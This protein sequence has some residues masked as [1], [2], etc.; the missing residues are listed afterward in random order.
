MSKV[1]QYLARKRHRS[2]EVLVHVYFQRL[3]CFAGLVQRINRAEIPDFAKST[4]NNCFGFEKF[5]DTLIAMQQFASNTCTSK[6]DNNIVGNNERT[7]STKE[8]SMALVNDYTM[9]FADLKR[10][11]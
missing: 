9:Y 2:S 1:L 3:L 6:A 7:S 10:H 4:E 11:R 8:H 5:L